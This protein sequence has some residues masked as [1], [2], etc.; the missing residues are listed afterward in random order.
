MRKAKTIILA[1]AIILSASFTLATEKAPGS[2]RT[3]IHTVLAPVAVSPLAKFDLIPRSAKMDAS[4]VKFDPDAQIASMKNGQRYLVRNVRAATTGDVLF[5]VNLATMVALN[6][7]DYFST[8]ACLSHPGFQ[9]WNPLLKPFVKSPVVFAAA[10][11][12]ITTLSYFA[13][14]ALYKKSKPL[15]W[16][17]SFASNLALA[18]VVS[19][20][21]RFHSSSK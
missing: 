6:G 15:A 7:A 18:Y 13:W 17:V 11:I 10:K 5:K 2:Q 19:S 8:N 12:G 20:N 16:I 4:F 9:E 3:I 1:I 21:I 14:T